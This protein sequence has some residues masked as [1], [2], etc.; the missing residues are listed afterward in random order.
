MYYTLYKDLNDITQTGR[1][2]CILGTFLGVLFVPYSLIYKLTPWPLGW[3][4][5]Y[6]AHLDSDPNVQGGWG[7]GTGTTNR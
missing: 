6:F 5:G 7:V 4:N 2:G 1:F 3:C